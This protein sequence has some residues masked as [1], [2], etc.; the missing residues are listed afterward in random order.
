MTPHPF[1]ARLADVID[2]HTAHDSRLIDRETALVAGVA[3][4]ARTIRGSSLRSSA[5][6]SPRRL[7]I[8]CGP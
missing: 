2:A 1:R 4:C 3:R 8:P 5:W 7:A 6:S